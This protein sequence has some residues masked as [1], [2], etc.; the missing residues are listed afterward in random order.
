LKNLLL[1]PE[2]KKETTKEKIVRKLREIVL[3]SRLRNTLK[4]Q[5]KNEK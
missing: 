3:V 4:D 5:I 1:N 2:L